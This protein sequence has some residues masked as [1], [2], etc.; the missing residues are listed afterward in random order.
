MLAYLEA[1]LIALDQLANTLL[2]GSADETLSARA[3]RTEADGKVLGSVL[4]PCIDALF[5]LL[6]FGRQTTHCFDAYESE[7][8]RRQL[9]THYQET[10]P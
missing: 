8:K 1:N 3:W 6:T 4:R 9:P 2:G 7:L 5:W 10:S